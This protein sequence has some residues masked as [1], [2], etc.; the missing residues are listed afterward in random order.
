MTATKF[1][2]A[3][4]QPAETAA[5]KPFTDAFINWTSARTA[6]E[7]DRMQKSGPLH[8]RNVTNLCVLCTLRVCRPL[9][10]FQLHL[11]R[12]TEQV[13]VCIVFGQS[14]R[15]AL[16]CRT[17]YAGTSC[18]CFGHQ[19]TQRLLLCVRHGRRK[20]EGAGEEE[21]R[22]HASPYGNQSTNKKTESQ[23]ASGQRT[24]SNLVRV[25]GFAFPHPPVCMES[26][27]SHAVI[28]GAG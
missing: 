9:R 18:A 28:H 4:N 5:V 12:C 14:V 22:L 10:R 26:C 21:R 1:A 15:D 16:R 6:L 2:R 27:M 11:A 17:R 7:E 24:T 20:E 13:S 25:P 23:R 8:V 3:A 19:L